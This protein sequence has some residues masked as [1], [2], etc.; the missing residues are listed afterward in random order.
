M[1]MTDKAIPQGQDG[2]DKAQ[3]DWLRLM[4]DGW[5]GTDIIGALQRENAKLRELVK[6]I[7]EVADPFLYDFIGSRKRALGI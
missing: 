2:L 7:D 1:Q 5:D 6:D 3:E 4:P